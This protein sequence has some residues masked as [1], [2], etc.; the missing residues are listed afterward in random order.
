MKQIP[1]LLCAVC[2]SELAGIHGIVEL[3]S[4][5]NYLFAFLRVSLSLCLFLYLCLFA[6]TRSPAACRLNKRSSSKCLCET[7]ASNHPRPDRVIAS[8]YVKHVYYLHQLTSLP[9]THPS[10]FAWSTLRSLIPHKQSNGYYVITGE[11]VIMAFCAN[12]EWPLVYIVPF[13]AI[14]SS[15]AAAR[16]R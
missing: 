13:H 1:E 14:V 3:E 16:L 2:N 8:S 4:E 11:T 15:A 9:S 5:Q 12:V 6:F 7:C 10:T